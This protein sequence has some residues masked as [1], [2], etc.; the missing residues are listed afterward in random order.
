VLAI[1][2]W[3]SYPFQPRQTINWV[4]S[5]FLVFLGTGI[6]WVLAQMYRDPILS[7]ITD[8]RPNELGWDFFI[9]VF[10]LGAVPFLTWVVYNY[11]EIGSTLFKLVQPGANFVK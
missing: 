11:P 4:F 6:V 10:S 9:K 8:K 5:F 7:R 3:N 2:A 1:V